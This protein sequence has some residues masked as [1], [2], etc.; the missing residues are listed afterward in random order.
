MKKYLT[1]INNGVFIKERNFSQIRESMTSIKV[2][3]RTI[4]NYLGMGGAI[5]EATAYNYSKLDNKSKKAFVRDYYSKDG[6]NYNFGRLSIGSN[7]FSLD[8]YEYATKKDLSDFSI[9]RD[10]VLIIPMIKDILMEKNIYFIA[11]PWSPPKVFKVLPVLNYGV[12]LKKKCYELYANYLYKWLVSYKNEGISIDYISMQNEPFAKQKWE[13]CIYSLNEQYDFVYNY[14]IP[15]LDNAKVLLWD[16]NKE[17]LYNIY[18]HLYL[19]NDK[20]AGIGFHYYTGP[21][22]DNIRSIRKENSKVLL[23]NTESCCGYSPY[24][25]QN[26]I[27]DAEIYLKDIMGDFNAGA[28]AYLD[29]NLFLDEFGGPCHVKNPV[30]SPIILKGNEY[31]KTP[32]YYYLYHISHFVQE[33]YE[34]KETTVSNDLITLAVNNNKKWI[35]IIMNVE[36]L[37]I[38]FDLE[39]CGKKYEDDIPKHSIITYV[40]EK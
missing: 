9:E 15:K 8:S 40:F 30:K 28:N 12:K 7:D 5:T 37:D 21:Y 25:E 24:N 20:V 33:G 26:W 23:I 11:A 27:N 35:I 6:L 36:D 18:K 2:T 34:I 13:S 14:L 10:K 16:H 29:W 38:T 1:D 32:I 39:I 31:I 4:S 17:N 3:D 19:D 22:F